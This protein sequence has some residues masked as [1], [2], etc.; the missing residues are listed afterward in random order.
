M[1]RRRHRGEDGDG[2]HSR[3]CPR[4][5]PSGRPMERH[6]NHRRL[7]CDR[8]RIRGHPRL[9]TPRTRA[10]NQNHSPRASARQKTPGAGAAEPRRGGGRHRRRH[11]RRPRPQGRACGPL[12]GRRHSRSQ[13]GLGHNH[14]RQLLRFNRARRHVGPLALPQHPAF[15]P[16]PAHDQLRGD[17]R[18]PRR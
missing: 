4:N 1:P 11:Q 15:H 8:P 3:H 13:G 12:D 16:L 10:E 14:H 9:G 5:R 2:R 6:R 7:R 17:R 18:L